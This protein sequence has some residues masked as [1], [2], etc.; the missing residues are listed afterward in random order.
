MKPGVEYSR[1]VGESKQYDLVVCGGG[2]AGFPAALSAARRGLSVLVLESKHQIG[3]TGTTGLVSHWLGGRSHVDASWVVGGIFRELSEEATWRGIAVLPKPSDYADKKYAP[4]GIFKGTLLAGVPFDPFE[5]APLLEKTLTDAGVDILYEMMVVDTM[6]QGD[7]ITHVI[8]A[9]KN[10]LRAIPARAFVDATGDGD[11]AMHSGCSYVDGAPD[12]HR[13][14]ISLM[15]HLENVAQ[16]EL[17]TYVTEEDDPRFKKKLAILRSEGVN[18]FNYEI[19]IFV[20]MNRE[21]YFMINGRPL[22]GIDG[23]DPASRTHAYVTERAKVSETL[24]LFRSRFPG[25]RDATLR[26]VASSVGVRETR[27]IEAVG[28]LSVKDVVDRKPL[29]DT[30]GYTDYGWDISRAE[31]EIDPHS[32]AKPP[33]IPIPYSVMVPKTISNLIFPG[34]AINCERLVLGPMRVQ[35]PF[36]AMGEAAGTAASLALAKG[37]SFADVDADTLRSEL[38][39]RGAIVDLEGVN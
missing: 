19:I 24:E 34:R 21:G 37:T 5:M 15:I 7:R 4:H 14:V 29:P 16:D 25:C 13:M 26:A 30:I 9:G 36:M 17:M 8:A 20:K 18:C 12:G 39:A 1:T 3:G 31:G 10:G 6:V 27:R 23:T 38:A 11:V 32:L 28:Y 33:V 2:P 22:G 35:C